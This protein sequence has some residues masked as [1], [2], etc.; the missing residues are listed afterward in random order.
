[1]GFRRDNLMPA[2]LAS[3]AV[4][5][6]G[7]IGLVLVAAAMHGWEHFHPIK[8][9]FWLAMLLYPAWGLLQQFLVNAM[10]ARNF[11]RRLPLAATVLLSSTL[12]GVIHLPDLTLTV[13]CGVAALVWIPIYLRWRNL[14]PLGVC[15]GWLGAITYYVLL[16]LDVFE[17]IAK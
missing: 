8:R 3:L 5:A 1:M 12:F 4:F 9:F 6:I 11:A 2:T 7:S 15:H 10:I 16:R 17:Q 13:L 14:W